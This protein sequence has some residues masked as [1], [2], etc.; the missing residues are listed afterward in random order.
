MVLGTLEVRQLF[1]TAVVI[2]T[3]Q[4]IVR[5]HDAKRNLNGKGRLAWTTLLSFQGHGM[6]APKNVLFVRFDFA[7]V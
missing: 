7:Q 1:E 2:L 4:N 5:L 3:D 6:E